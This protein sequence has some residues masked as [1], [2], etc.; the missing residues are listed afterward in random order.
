M[1][2]QHLQYDYIQMYK[3]ESVHF[4]GLLTRSHQI[5]PFARFEVHR[6]SVNEPLNIIELNELLF[7]PADSP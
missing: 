3:E 4:S 7:N 2:G 1:A 5:G 6:L